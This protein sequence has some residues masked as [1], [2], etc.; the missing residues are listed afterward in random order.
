[1]RAGVLGAS[2]SPSSRALPRRR[3][4]LPPAPA[5][6]LLERKGERKKVREDLGAGRFGRRRSATP[7]P[8]PRPR[9]HGLLA[10][11]AGGELGPSGRARPGAGGIRC[12]RQLPV[13]RARARN[14]RPAGRAIN[15]AAA[16]PG[17]AQP[18]QARSPG[19]AGTAQPRPRGRTV[20]GPRRRPVGRGRWMSPPPPPPSERLLSW[21]GVVGQ[22][23]CGPGIGRSHRA[24]GRPGRPG[25]PAPLF[26]RGFLY[27]PLLLP[28]LCE[29][30]PFRTGGHQPSNA[31]GPDW[32]RTLAPGFP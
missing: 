9:P 26:V 8:C 30:N 31:T 22:P 19:T 20:Q 15:N 12:R 24:E 3:A 4:T 27:C 11:P 6:G 2:Q 1:M 17:V 10:P 29:K 13:R 5:T 18:W 14:K 16:Q 25:V 32:P 23:G 21:L 28:G 7:H